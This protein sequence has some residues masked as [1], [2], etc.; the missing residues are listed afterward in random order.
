[1][2][3]HADAI[4]CVFYHLLNMKL[5]TLQQING[6]SFPYHEGYLLW[7][8]MQLLGSSYNYAA[9]P[10][11]IPNGVLAT[12]A[13]K[14]FVK[15]FNTALN[16]LIEVNQRRCSYGFDV[17]LPVNL[18]SVSK[19]NPINKSL[20][21]LSTDSV[22][23]PVPPE[24]FNVTNWTFTSTT[25]EGL[26]LELYNI[27][28]DPIRFVP[29]THDLGYSQ[30]PWSKELNQ[31]GIEIQTPTGNISL[32][33]PYIHLTGELYKNPDYVNG[34]QI[35]TNNFDDRYSPYNLES[36]LQIYEMNSGSNPYQPV[37]QA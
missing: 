30:T 10:A 37:G 3:S 20:I 8:L 17:K 25:V 15:P 4:L 32:K 24:G 22:E 33:M 19:G 31:Q 2:L 11:N 36:A 21:E 23:L 12:K 7:A 26:I 34:A 29:F 9:M 6:L 14:G 35:D 1:M 5:P 28:T 27:I 13:K 16:P 18:A